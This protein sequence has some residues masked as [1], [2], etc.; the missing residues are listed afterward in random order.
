MTDEIEIGDEEL[1][2]K[3]VPVARAMTCLPEVGDGA[4]LEIDTRLSARNNRYGVH[5]ATKEV[6]AEDAYRYEESV[7]GTSVEAPGDQGK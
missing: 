5:H 7:L 4:L 6:L 1:L 2:F 3:Y